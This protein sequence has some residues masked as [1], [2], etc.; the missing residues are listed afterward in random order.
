MVAVRPEDKDGV[1]YATIR[2]LP[3]YAV[4]DDGVILT[5][6]SKR[7]S[8]KTGVW[9]PVS[10][11]RRPYGGRYCVVSLRENGGVGKVVCRYV[12]RLVLEAFVG[13]CPEGME[14]C[15][16]N[17][18]TADNRLVNLRWDTKQANVADKLKHGTQPA[19]SLSANATLTADDVIAVYLL[20]AAGHKQEDIGA[21]LGVGQNTISG[22]LGGTAYPA[23]KAAI[24]PVY[25][26][27]ADI[28]LVGVPKHMRADPTELVTADC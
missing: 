7:S 25:A 26:R 6:L 8:H 10:V 28:L 11:Y 14:A 5:R 15:H 1:R 19:G 22:I 9:A 18:D 4:G 17:G 2:G 3:G 21:I 20:A 24:A 16:N 27:Y 13:P 23:E 12:H